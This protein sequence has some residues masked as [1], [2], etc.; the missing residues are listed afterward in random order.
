[1]AN[2]VDVIRAIVDSINRE[3]TVKSIAGLKVFVCSTLWITLGKTIEDGNG[4]KYKVTDFSFDEWIELQV[5]G[6]SPAPY[7]GLVVVAPEPKFFYGTPSS[8]NDEYLKIKSRRTLKKTPFIWF[9]GSYEYESPA[10]DSPIE[11]GLDG[12]LFFM[13]GAQEIKWTTDQHNELVI[14]PMNNLVDAFV[15][16]VEEDYSFK[17]LGSYSRRPRERFGVEVANQGNTRKI[18]DEDLSGIDVRI[19]LE[20]FD[21]S[22]CDV[23]C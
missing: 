16:V 22:I 21:T 17:T 23:N 2:G 4:N 18:I 7:E 13:D 1:M 20:L 3:T 8:L 14:K 10:P 9:L 12:R 11:M 6:N 19:L 15:N 5:I